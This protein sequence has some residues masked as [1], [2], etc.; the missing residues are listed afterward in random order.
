MPSRCRE[1]EGPDTEEAPAAKAAKMLA[2]HS[3]PEP[4][5][6]Q[7]HLAPRQANRRTQAGDE[8]SVAG[9]LMYPG[10]TIEVNGKKCKYCR[11]DATKV[12]WTKIDGLVCDAC[13][14]S[15]KF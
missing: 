4:P 13:I 3:E 5:H 15:V 8:K 1:A 10:R 7:P 2:A 9:T 6:P 12:R 14:S 11:S